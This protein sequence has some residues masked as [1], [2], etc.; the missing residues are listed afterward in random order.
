MFAPPSL[1]DPTVAHVE[2]AANVPV[3]SEN[4]A[5]ESSLDSIVNSS[6]RHMHL[7]LSLDT[8]PAGTPELSSLLTEVYN[9]K[10]I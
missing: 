6:A 7:S 8:V 5:E 1:N 3:E 4:S 9:T 2:N 10:V